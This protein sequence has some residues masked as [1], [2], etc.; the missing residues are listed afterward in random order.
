[1]M[2]HDKFADWSADLGDAG[3]QYLNR[4][5]V[6][7]GTPPIDLPKLLNSEEHLDALDAFEA[8]LKQK[9]RA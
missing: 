7:V 9:P 8:Q 1:M 5:K 6:A 2:T 3:K 4:Q